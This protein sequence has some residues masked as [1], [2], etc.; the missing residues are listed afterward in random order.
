MNLL[1]IQ[2]LDAANNIKV[3]AIYKFKKNVCYSHWLKV[4]KKMT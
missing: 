4:E 3:N 1:N 2:K